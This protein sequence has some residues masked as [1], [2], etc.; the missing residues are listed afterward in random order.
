MEGG[1]TNCP[2]CKA[3]VTLPS[4]PEP[5]FLALMVGGGAMVLG[6]SVVVGIAVSPL[7]GFIT[8]AVL[9]SIYGLSSLVM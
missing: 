5:L 7:A 8:F 3:L 1:V 2:D 4:G 6:V 9:A